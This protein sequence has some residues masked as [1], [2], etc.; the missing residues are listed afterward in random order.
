M[1]TTP[2]SGPPQWRSKAAAIC[3]A[4]LPAPTTTVRPFGRS[5]RLAAITFSGSAAATAEVNRVSRKRR[6]SVM[7]GICLP[8]EHL[9][10]FRA[11]NRFT[12]FLELPDD[13]SG[14]GSSNRRPD[15]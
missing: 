6:G 12:L 14:G 8:L 2:E 7:A 5:G 4:P 13:V 3:A 11:E 1:T 10:N 15:T 9:R